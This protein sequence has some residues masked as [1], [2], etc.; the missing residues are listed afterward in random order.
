MPRLD[1]PSFAKVLKLS[2][3]RA[4]VVDRG[5]PARIAAAGSRRRG[6]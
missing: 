4:T 6:G 1:I 3:D 5:P 2:S